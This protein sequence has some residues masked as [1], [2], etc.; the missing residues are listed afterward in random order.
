MGRKIHWTLQVAILMAAAL[1]SGVGVSVGEGLAASPGSV[2]TGLSSMSNSV[3]AFV[4]IG[5]AGTLAAEAPPNAQS[6][7]NQTPPAS[8]KK[9][10]DGSP[11]SVIQLLKDSKDAVDKK[12][13]GKNGVHFT[14]NFTLSLEGVMINARGEGDIL[15]PDQ[16]DM[17]MEFHDP[18]VEGD[19]GQLMDVVITSSNTYLKPYWAKKWAS[20][21]TRHYQYKDAANGFDFTKF[22]LNPQLLGKETMRNGVQAYH[23]R[24]DID[25]TAVAE[26][27]EHNVKNNMNDLSPE[28]L[29]K[30]KA[31]TISSDFWIGT[32]DLLPYQVTERFL[33]TELLIAFDDMMLFYDWGKEVVIS[34][35]PAEEIIALS[36]E[37]LA[38]LGIDT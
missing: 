14:G 35:P 15:P 36:D 16:C 13:A 34:P 20:Y 29:E 23:V 11:E 21:S 26:Q 19:F 22:I 7:N 27:V 25:A 6:D 24:V 28:K 33:N 9:P 2:G 8:G 32:N 31:S 5:A 4:I 10:Y 30:L 17:W 3:P 38:E 37:E 12:T 1:I 18:Y